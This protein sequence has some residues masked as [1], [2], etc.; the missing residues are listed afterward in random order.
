MNDRTSSLAGIRTHWTPAYGDD[1]LEHESPN[2]MPEL[3][4][5]ETVAR[6]LDPLV[7]GRRVTAVEVFDERIDTGGLTVLVGRRIDRVLRMGKQVV[8]QLGDPGDRRWLAV[9][10]RMTGRLRVTDGRDEDGRHVRARVRMDRGSVDFV[11]ARR[12]GTM[13]SYRRLAD[14][15]PSGL[16]P[17]S[18]AHTAATL[19]TL[20]GASSQPIKPWLLRQDRLVGIGNIYASEILFACRLDPRRPARSLAEP[21]VRRLHRAIR[22]VLRAA[23]DACGT[24]FSDFQDVRGTEGSFGAFLA[25]YGR[26]GEPCRRCKRPVERLVQAGRST[27]LCARCQG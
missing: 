4:E 7:R 24:T 11:D 26:R 5:V 16:E 19:A 22:R 18:A 9:H 25:V 27:F 15:R 23:I 10:L 13:C 14:V 1:N 2:A 12:F 3:P 20:L 8:F 6:Q 21:E 17:L